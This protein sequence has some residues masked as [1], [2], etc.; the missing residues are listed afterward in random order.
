MRSLEDTTARHKK[1]KVRARSNVEPP[2]Q[3][4]D[5]FSAAA[6]VSDAYDPLVEGG[7]EVGWHAVSRSDFFL[8]K[9]FVLAG[10][11]GVEDNATIVSIFPLNRSERHDAIHVQKEV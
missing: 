4:L 10:Q 1:S 11:R 5:A 8:K 2:A 7:L 9:Q 3:V 6:S